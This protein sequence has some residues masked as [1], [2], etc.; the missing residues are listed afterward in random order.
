MSVM[1]RPVAPAD[2]P[3]I[4][5]I[6]NH[7]VHHTVVTFEEEP[8][9][10]E[11]M[12]N[13]IADVTSKLFWLVIEVDGVVAGYAYAVPWKN[14]SAYRFS[15]ESTI[16]LAPEAGGQ[17]L[18]SQ[19]YGAV[20]DELRARGIHSVVGG[21]ALPNAGSVALHEKMGYRKVAH[22]EQTGWKFGAWVDVGYWQLLL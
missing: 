15:T 16:Y 18:G 6:Y 19:L 21:I 22:F 20:I 1:I 3:R 17:G 5:D 7:Y 2:V 13:R 11:E 4:C 14:R 8:V 9:P 10:V 12:E